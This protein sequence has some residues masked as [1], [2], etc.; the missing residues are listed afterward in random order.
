PTNSITAGEQVD[1]KLLPL[2]LVR[3][4]APAELPGLPARLDDQREV[5][6]VGLEGRRVRDVKLYALADAAAVLVERGLERGRTKGH[7][8]QA[9]AR[10]SAGETPPV[11]ERRA[12]QLERARRPAALG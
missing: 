8:A 3:R 7:P 9:P 5:C 4:A 12:D 1:R 11:E 2:E 10:E 6:G